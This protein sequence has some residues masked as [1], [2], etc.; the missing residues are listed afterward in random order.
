[1]PQPLILPIALRQRMLEHAGGAP[2]EEVCG[3]LG[4]RDGVWRNYYPVANDAPDRARRFSMNPAQQIAA[5]RSMRERQE[6]LC[7]IFHS[8]TRPPAAPSAIDLALAAWPGVCY[9]IA[10]PAAT[11]LELRAFHF[12]GRRFLAVTLA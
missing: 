5:L 10:A 7:G 9:L 8:H 4:A 3:L 2:G 11:G 6:T 1:M 12:D